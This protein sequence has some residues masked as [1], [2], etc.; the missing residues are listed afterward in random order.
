MD[1]DKSAFGAV[2]PERLEDQLADDTG[3]LGMVEH[4][5]AVLDLDTQLLTVS[6]RG[7]VTLRRRGRQ[8]TW[9]SGTTVDRDELRRV[10]AGWVAGRRGR[11]PM[12]S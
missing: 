4:T 6:G 7:G 1:F 5:A 3:I 8:W 2:E 11:F 9:P 12:C 10:V